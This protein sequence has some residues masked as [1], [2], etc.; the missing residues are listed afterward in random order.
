MLDVDDLTIITIH[1]LPEPDQA[2]KWGREN[3]CLTPRRRASAK[4]RRT[5]AMPADEHRRDDIAAAVAAYNRANPSAALPPNAAQL[6]AV[7]FPSEDVCQRSQEAI[8]AEGFSRDRLPAM[9]QR[10]VEAGLLSRHRVAQVPDTYRLHLPALVQ[11]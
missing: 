3:A 1:H 7:M 2:P 9:L 4:P 8:A 5:R 10:L 6:L 11:S